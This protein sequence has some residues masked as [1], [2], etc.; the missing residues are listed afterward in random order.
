MYRKGQGPHPHIRP[1]PPALCVPHPNNRGGDPV[2]SLRSRQLG[3]TLA[4]DGYDKFDANNT[5]VAVQETPQ[6]QAANA[7][8]GR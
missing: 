2:V 4:K 3:N 7:K 8:E 6:C 5:A 1:F